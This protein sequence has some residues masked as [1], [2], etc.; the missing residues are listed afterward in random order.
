MKTM[1]EML[2]P[3]AAKAGGFGFGL[4]LAALATARFCPFWQ[5]GFLF[6]LLAMGIGIGLSVRKGGDE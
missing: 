3:T 4:A 2:K 1:R 6:G 5:A